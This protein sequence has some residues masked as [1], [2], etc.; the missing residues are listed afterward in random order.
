MP[1]RFRARLIRFLA[2]LVVSATLTTGALHAATQDDA[3]V[4][5]KV[6]R[7]GEDCHVSIRL[8]DH[9]KVK[10]KIKE[11]NPDSVVMIRK[12][13]SALQTVEFKEMK[14]LRTRSSLAGR[15]APGP[16]VGPITMALASP[17]ILTAAFLG[18]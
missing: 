9:S 8:K 13:S 11:I 4:L 18:R 17:F 14:S 16:C 5:K 6:S 3:S 2:L 7:C 10:G 12:G 15:F 1:M